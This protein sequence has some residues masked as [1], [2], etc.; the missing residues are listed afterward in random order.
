M[1]PYPS[2][3]L[4][5]RFPYKFAATYFN[6]AS[7]FRFSFGPDGADAAFCDEDEAA[8]GLALVNTLAVTVAAPP[9]GRAT[10]GCGWVRRLRVW[11]AGGRAWPGANCIRFIIMGGIARGWNTEIRQAQSKFIV[12]YPEWRVRSL[13]GIYVNIGH[14]NIHRWLSHLC[15]MHPL[16]LFIQVT[17]ARNFVSMSFLA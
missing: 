1:W 9:P 16:L 17:K 6:E 8:P 2:L 11:L 13:G 7:Y 15:S 10:A 4:V 12:F 14:E 5:V 3:A